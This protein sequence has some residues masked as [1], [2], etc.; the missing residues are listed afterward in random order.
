MFHRVHRPGRL[1]PALVI[2]VLGFFGWGHASGASLTDT[3][4]RWLAAAQ[5]V[6]AYARQAGLPV[7]IIVQPTARPELS[8][9]SMAY[10]GG[11]C[12]LVLTMRGN[13]KV[14]QHLEGMPPVLH[15]VLIEAM[16]AHEL[17]HCWRHR[18]GAWQALP[19]GFSAPSPHVAA[20]LVPGADAQRLE[21]GFADLVGLAW[22]SS[23][24][25]AHYAAVHA[26]L[27]DEREGGHSGS[28]HDTRLWVRMAADASVFSRD[29]NLFEQALS[30]W[31]AGLR[32][33]D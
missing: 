25:P 19:S 23:R 10:L 22:T 7:D 18:Q 28:A 5:P 24:H 15:P 8:P 14:E 12:K 9:L 3:E 30:P 1:A 16:A 29:T 17:G 2:L 20:P 27:M 33:S 32:D 6:L 11:R 13:P 21:E 4:Q 26:W 31:E